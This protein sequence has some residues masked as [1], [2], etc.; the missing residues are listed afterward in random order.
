MNA[1]IKGALAQINTSYKAF[2]HNGKRMSKE[3]V[4]AV[5]EYAD[6]VGYKTTDQIPD[7]EIDEI[8]DKLN[9]RG[10]TIYKLK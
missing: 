4:K 1:D 6:Q 8:I 9:C 2:I 5:L 7:K 10:K 3:Q